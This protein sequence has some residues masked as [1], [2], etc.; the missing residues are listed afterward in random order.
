MNQPTPEMDEG[1]LEERLKSKSGPVRKRA[2]DQ[3]AEELTNSKSAEQAQLFCPL[4]VEMVNDNNAVALDSAFSVALAILNLIPDFTQV[5][6]IVVPTIEKGLIGKTST[7]S[8]ALDLLMLLVELEKPEVISCLVERFE[9]K[10]PK[11]A[12][13][14]ILAARELLHSFGASVI[15]VQLLCRNMKPLFTSTNKV[16]KP[17]ASFLLSFLLFFFIFKNNH[18]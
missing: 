2:Y 15:N 14:S 9:H 6:E 17:S 8:K 13:C 11:I 4:L 18:N 12:S 16:S 1:S 5:N 10:K 7:S 3:L